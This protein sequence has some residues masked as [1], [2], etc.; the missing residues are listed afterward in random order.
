MHA[1]TPPAVFASRF[2]DDHL[3][4][5]LQSLAVHSQNVTQI[6]AWPN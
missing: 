2:P 5:T 1:R 4:R 6:T 3:K